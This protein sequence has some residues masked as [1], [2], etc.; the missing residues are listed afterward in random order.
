MKFDIA[1]TMLGLHGQTEMTNGSIKPI[2]SATFPRR[3]FVAVAVRAKTFTAAGRR[4]LTSPTRKRT[5]RNVSP[6]IIIITIVIN[7]ININFSH[8]IF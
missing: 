1:Y 5:L 6:L 3:V 4:L 8:T 2:I 7:L